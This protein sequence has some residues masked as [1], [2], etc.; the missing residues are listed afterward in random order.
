M[1]AMPDETPTFTLQVGGSV[2]GGI[3]LVGSIGVGG[4]F[5]GSNTTF[6]YTVS[7]LSNTTQTSTGYETVGGSLGYVGHNLGFGVRLTG[8]ADF[9]VGAQDTGSNIS[10]VFS[11]HLILA[12]V[13]VIVPTNPNLGG[14]NG[15]GIGITVGPGLYGGLDLEGS[16]SQTLF[17]NL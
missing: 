14:W 9:V 17:R 12:G 8:G 3:P 10:A 5:Y 15:Y 16:T 13:R 11:A 1:M 6:G 2:T 4:N 7:I